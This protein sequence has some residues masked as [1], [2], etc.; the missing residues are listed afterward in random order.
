MKKHSFFPVL[1]ALL[2]IVSSGLLS[3]CVASA[4]PTAV[5]VRPRPYYR[6]APVVVV[7]PRPMVVVPRR[8][9]IVKPAPRA[10]YPYR[11][12]RFSGRPR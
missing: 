3:G 11:P 2:A 10:Y 7:A 6:P 12:H 8:A 9:V 4:R 5:V 1:L